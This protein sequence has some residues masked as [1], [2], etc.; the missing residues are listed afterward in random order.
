MN[1]KKL[2]ITGFEPFGGDSINPSWEAVSRLPEEIGDFTV[3]KLRIPV[4]FSVS[5]RRVIEKAREISPDVIICVG[6]AGGREKVCLERVAI[7]IRNASIPDNAG[8]K[9]TDE[10]IVEGGREAF[11]STAV[12][13]D[14]VD[15]VNEK[16]IPCA[17]SYHAGAYVCNDV[18]YTLLHTFNGT[19][20]RV[21]FIHVP[22]LPEQAEEGKPSMELDKITEALVCALECL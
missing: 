10:M 11:F 5:A 1:N 16:G 13:R 2:L 7:N 8:A 12:S 17:M 14:M 15:A 4:E 9:P 3:T 6:E 22:R 19:D 21:G 18:L 20:T